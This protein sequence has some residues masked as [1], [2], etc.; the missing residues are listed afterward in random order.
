MKAVVW[1]LPCQYNGDLD[2]P[3]LYIQRQFA[4]KDVWLRVFNLPSPDEPCSFVVNLETGA[5]R[6]K[7]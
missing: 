7:A 6:K 1:N 4:E 5:A 3:E 2:G